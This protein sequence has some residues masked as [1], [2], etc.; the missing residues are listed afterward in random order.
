MKHL[1]LIVVLVLLSGC[2]SVTRFDEKARKLV[3]QGGSL[4]SPP[5]YMPGDGDDRTKELKGLYSEL[6]SPLSDD[7]KSF[8]YA[9]II[10]IN[11]NYVKYIDVLTAGR[12]GVN[13]MYDSLNLALTGAATV[14]TPAST[15]TALAGLSTFFQGQKQSVDKNL[16]DDKAIFALTSIMEVRRSQILI[17]LTEKLKSPTYTLGEAVFD[18]DSLYRAG[19]LQIALQAA[20]L[21]QPGA[22][23]ANKDQP[24]LPILNTGTLNK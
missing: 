11:K 19:S 16:F 9:A 17:I 23:G 22:G 21:N 13:V 3:K 6:G 10:D 15:K 2:T 1:F 8:V 18:L 4:Y 12:A 14:A 24:L 20:F 5:H 7:G